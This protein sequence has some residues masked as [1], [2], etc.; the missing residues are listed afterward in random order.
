MITVFFK[1]HK[2][3]TEKDAIQLQGETALQERMV[4]MLRNEAKLAWM[5]PPAHLGPIGGVKKSFSI[6][7]VVSTAH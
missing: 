1:N 6:R 5:P 3:E 2:A 7:K 4:R